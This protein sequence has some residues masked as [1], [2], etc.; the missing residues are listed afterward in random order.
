MTMNN[1]LVLQQIRDVANIRVRRD[2]GFYGVT[3]PVMFR[4]PGSF[5][6]T[7]YDC[8]STPFFTADR[9]YRIVAVIERHERASTDA[10]AK[11]LKLKRVPSGA[12]P[13]SGTD[14]L[15]A[16]LDLSTAADTNQYGSVNRDA[17]TIHTGDSLSFIL[18]AYAPPTNLLGVSVAV[19]LRSL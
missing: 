6:F 7:S 14:I 18:D 2:G 16:S 3:K 11:Y 17:D 13:A 1:D 5:A 12:A 8:F 10:S 19:L 4:M 15:T 9:S